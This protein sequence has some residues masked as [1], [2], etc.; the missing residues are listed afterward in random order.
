MADKKKEKLF[1][2]F[3]APTRQEWIDKIIVDLKGAG[4]D[5]LGGFLA[6]YLKGNRGNRL[7]SCCK[8][9]NDAASVILRNVGCTYPKNL[10]LNLDDQC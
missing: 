7:F 3:Q 9:G 8:T 10:K 2:E 4:D 1:S 6:M 5:F